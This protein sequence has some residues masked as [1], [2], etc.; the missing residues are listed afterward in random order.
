MLDI[1]LLLATISQVPPAMPA[2]QLVADEAAVA[3][4][5]ERLHDPANDVRAAAA[6][7]LREIVARYP[8]GTADLRHADSGKQAWL[9]RLAQVTPGMP[10]AQVK[11]ILPPAVPATDGW[12]HC[13]GD[14]CNLSYRLDPHWMIALVLRQPGTLI[15]VPELV[16]REQR[17][18]VE[19]PDGYTGTWHA[20]HV[21]GQ[22]AYE[23]Q[24]ENGKYQGRFTSYHDNGQRSVEQHYLQHVVH[25]TD[26]GWNPDGS[27]SYEASYT[28]GKQEGTW[29]HYHDDGSP[30]H[31]G[32]YRHGQRH[33]RSATWD[34]AGLLRHEV[35]Y[36]HDVK[37]GQEASW[38]AQGELDYLHHYRDG[39][40]VD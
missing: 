9:D 26:T 36:R 37:D 18:Y 40:L 5:Q 32:Q 3:A 21:N 11:Q 17:I 8:S 13:S 10:V 24:F 19:P 25:G 34:E 29:T 12:E 4:A 30:R 39:E 22:P 28:N 35:H 38:N 15:R 31:M 6:K 7:K 33:G 1:L 27:L 14:S 20:W 23:I 2:E 16:A